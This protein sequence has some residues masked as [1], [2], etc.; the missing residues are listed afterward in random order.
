METDST[1]PAPAGSLDGG[2]GAPRKVNCGELR[3]ADAG[4]VALLNGWVHRRRDHGGLIFLDMRDRWGMTQV[5]CNPADAPEAAAVAE[6]VRSE[7]VVQ[8]A[9]RCALRPEG[10]RNP[11]LPTG[12]IEVAAQRLTDPQRGQAAAVR[13]RGRRPSPTR[14]CASNTA[15]STCAAAS[16]QRNLILRHRMIKFIRD[17]LDARGFIEIETPILV[18]STPE[19]AR[20]YLV[21]SRVHPGAVLRPAAVAAAVQAVAD[22]RRASTAT[23]RSRAASATRTCAPTASRSSRSSTWR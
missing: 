2:S 1:P 21:P 5:V 3:A 16:M 10:M 15:T 14:C 13:H 17:Y 11:K 18:K 8:A 20:D 9:G 6:T 7:Y 23:S 19:G 4:S 22:G 12:E